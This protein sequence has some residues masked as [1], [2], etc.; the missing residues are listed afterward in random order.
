VTKE[1]IPIITCGI[2]LYNIRSKKLLVCHATHSTWKIWTIPKGIKDSSENS[3]TAAS[4]ELN[5]ETG[6]DISTIHI[7]QKYSLPSVK[8]QKQNKI[9]ESF[10]VI[11]DSDLDKHT[12]TC[13]TI[14]NNEFPEIDKWKWINPE[15]IKEILHES[16]QKNFDLIDK[17]I[18]KSCNENHSEN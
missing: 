12:F 17:L 16:Q 4:R 8:Y 6:I 14:I 10:L 5:E 11:T 15:L 7:L 9:L 13:S 18:K 2:Y 3:F 1:K